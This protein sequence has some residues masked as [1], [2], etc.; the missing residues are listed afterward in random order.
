[1]KTLADEAWLP[2]LADLAGSR[3]PA[4]FL[5]LAH[6]L[7]GAI[8]PYRTAVAWCGMTTVVL[9]EDAEDRR[10]RSRQAVRAHF[11]QV[12]G[13]RNLSERMLAYYADSLLTGGFL[14][15][16]LGDPPPERTRML[17]LER[18][19]EAGDDARKHLRPLLQPQAWDYALIVPLHVDDEELHA[20]LVY[21]RTKDEGPFNRAQAARIE[22]LRPILA[23]MLARLL[24]HRQQS[25]TQ[26]DILEFLAEFPVGLM[27]FDGQWRALFV[28]EEA[29]RQTQLWLHAP[30]APPRGEN[31]RANFRLPAEIRAAGERLRQRSLAE[32][33]GFTPAKGALHES[34]SH[35]QRKDMKASV[36]I[37]QARDNGAARTPGVLVR[38]SGMAA[39]IET[40]FQPSPSQLSILSQLTPGER[41]VALLVKRGMSNQEIADALHRDIT[42]V[43][44]HL[45]HVYDKL[46]IRG[47]TQLAAMLAG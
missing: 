46:G 7:L 24:E 12:D 1:M 26:S 37:L 34:V 3:E 38:Y 16:A 29:Y 4:E 5:A 17:T 36:T 30:T 35:P 23:A 10:K 8:V 11:D 45:S 20:G 18:L 19:R 41:N 33:L 21:Y 22:M 15:A 44:D 27:L 40:T 2:Q 47:R 42:T 14:L 6:T 13:M 25:S 39:R 31:A 32:A 43:K 9:G 28:N